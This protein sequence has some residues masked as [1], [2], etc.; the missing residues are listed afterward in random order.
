MHP[1]TS[2]RSLMRS[3]L[4]AVT[5][6]ALAFAETPA[7]SALKSRRDE[8]H[9][10][11]NEERL[12]R[13]EHAQRLMRQNQLG[14]IALGGGT[15]MFYFSGVRWGVSERLFLMILPAQGEPFFVAPA[16]EKDRA[17]EL[18]G[19]G[20]FGPSTRVFTWEENVSPYPVVAM[21][22]KDRGLATARIGME[23]RMPFVFASGIAHALPGAA[24]LSA[25]PVT[26]GC[27]MIKSP[28][29]I[30]LMRLANSVTLQAY[31]AAW[32]SLHDGMTQQEFGALIGAAYEK[33]GFKGE[34]SVVVDEGSALPHGSRRPQA[35]RENSIVLIDDGCSVEGYQ[36][37]ISRTFVFG[38]PTD[39]MKRVFDIVH[40]AQSAALAAAHPGVACETVDAAARK[41]ISDGGYGPGY[42][43][44]THRVGH[45]I[46]LDGHEW[47]YLTAVNTLEEGNHGIALAPDMTFSDEPGI[48]LPGDFGI[49]LEDDMHILESG[50]ELFTPQ[51]PSLEDP[52]GK[53]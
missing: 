38:K 17:L 2:R 36:S 4:C 29:E 6:S 45:G 46:G 26:A 44:F 22:L 50:A 35:I 10:I 31:Q 21:A 40:R 39:K 43:Y 25:T 47:P 28:N 24:I 5:G 33:L 1:N 30:A 14:A 15:S 32:K 51:S 7:I 3:A 20:P 41:V 16:F 48:Y 18:I 53:R 49:R 13:V 11:P 8:A 9:P 23:E 27:R 19:D 52:F 34:A 37:D 42:K 12:A